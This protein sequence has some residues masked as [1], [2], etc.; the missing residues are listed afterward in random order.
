MMERQLEK[1]FEREFHRICRLNVLVFWG[2]SLTNIFWN[3][4]VF[5]GFVFEPRII[6]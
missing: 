4:R 1:N 5:R 6:A 2:I 3:R